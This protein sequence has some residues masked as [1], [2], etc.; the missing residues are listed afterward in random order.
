MVRGGSRAASNSK[1]KSKSIKKEDVGDSNDSAV[2]LN[3]ANVSLLV[4]SKENYG[5]FAPRPTVRPMQL[6]ASPATSD[7]EEPLDRKSLPSKRGRGRGRGRPPGRKNSVKEPRGRGRPSVKSANNPTRDRGGDDLLDYL[8]SRFRR[9]L[10][11]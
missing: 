11:N 8:V 3:I 4:K 6:S 5:A 7:D 9:V 2:P 1:N 10:R